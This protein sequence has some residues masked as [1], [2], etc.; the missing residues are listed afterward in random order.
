MTLLT[1]MLYAKAGNG[2]VFTDPVPDR[3]FY[4]KYFSD[5]NLSRFFIGNPIPF[6][7][8]ILSTRSDNFIPCVFTF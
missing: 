7:L 8:K 1:S 5:R 4:R 6:P 3:C 2:T